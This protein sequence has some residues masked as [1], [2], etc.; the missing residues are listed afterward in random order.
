MDSDILQAAE[1]V[2]IEREGIA[3]FD[4]M[5]TRAEAVRT[6][7]TESDQYRISN[8]IRFACAL[9]SKAER[10]E[11]FTLVEKRDGPEY[12]KQLRELAQKH[13]TD[14]QKRKADAPIKTTDALRA[15]T[16]AKTL[17]R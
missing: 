4:G 6:G 10:D 2:R 13:W 15:M 14:K 3:Q 7:K 11:Y 16:T 8:Q 9:G 1:E 12:A 17:R 5:L